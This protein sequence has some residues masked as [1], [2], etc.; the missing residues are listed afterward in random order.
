VHAHDRELVINVHIH[1]RSPA[2]CVF[3]RVTSAIKALQTIEQFTV[4]LM[5]LLPVIDLTF[6]AAVWSPQIRIVHEW[7]NK[8]V[9]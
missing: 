9:S 2:R 8:Q 1:A 5:S 3:D 7:F 6:T 4:V